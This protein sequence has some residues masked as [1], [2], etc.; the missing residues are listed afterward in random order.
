MAEIPLKGGKAMMRGTLK[1]AMVVVFG[2]WVGFVWGQGGYQK[3]VKILEKL[4]PPVKAK[5]V[6]LLP[7]TPVPRPPTFRE[8]KRGIKMPVPS[9]PAMAFVRKGKV[10]VV[11]DEKRKLIECSLEGKILRELPFPKGIPK[12]HPFGG[13]V[14]SGL[15][16]L[17]GEV[18]WVGFEGLP[19]A[20]GVD[21]RRWEIVE[22]RRWKGKGLVAGLFAR[23]RDLY[24]IMPGKVKGYEVIWKVVRVREGGEQ[25]GQMK[26]GWR[27]SYVD[28]RG[29]V[30][31]V[32]DEGKAISRMLKVGYGKF[33]QEPRVIATI[34]LRHRKD[35]SLRWT[36]GGQ[37]IGVIGDTIIGFISF[38][39]RVGKGEWVGT[40]SFLVIRRDGSY[41]IV[42]DLTE[43]I[44]E[45]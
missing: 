27:P 10:Y 30:Y 24:V 16:S 2:A 13:R 34:D 25:E 38:D 32:W 5:R 36:S 4:L 1:M 18:L 20:F 28:E 40:Y 21:L 33:G 7:L 29:G 44:G 37:V 22:E 12:R 11:D 39:I 42:G 17:W 45:V 31:W 35:I 6:T 23:G 15:M 41:K 9:G 3:G 14:L 26:E 8:Y 43:A 19:Y